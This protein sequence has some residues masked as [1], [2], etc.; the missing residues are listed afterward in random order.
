LPKRLAQIRNAARFHRLFLGGIVINR[1]HKENWQLG[2]RCAQLTVEFEAGNATQMNIQKKAGCIGIAGPLEESFGGTERFGDKSVEAQKTGHATNHARIIIN[3]QHQG[4]WSAISALASQIEGVQVSASSLTLF[5]QG[6]DPE[7]T[8]AN[9]DA[10][11]ETVELSPTSARRLIYP[12]PK[13]ATQVR[14]SG[15]P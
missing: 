12:K 14:C 2:S 6:V 9:I 3:Y 1:R 5:S 15:H 8:I 11:V 4:G 7:L 10:I 13:A